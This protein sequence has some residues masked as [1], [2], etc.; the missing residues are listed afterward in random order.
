MDSMRTCSTGVLNL[1]TASV[2]AMIEGLFAQRPPSARSRSPTGTGSKNVGAAHDE[3][4]ASLKS[5]CESL[6]YGD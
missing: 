5:T 1:D 2:R 3:R 4:M 6:T